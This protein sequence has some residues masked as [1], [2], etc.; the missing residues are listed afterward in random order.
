MPPGH[1]SMP[2]MRPQPGMP[3]GGKPVEKPKAHGDEH[4]KGEHKPD[5]C[6]GH[7]PMDPPGR[8]NFGHGLL[9][10]DNAKAPPPPEDPHASSWAPSLWRYENKADPCDP[11]NEPPPFLA[12]LLNFGVLVFL[13][14]RFGRK[15]IAAALVKRKQTIMHDIDV[16]KKLK[17]DAKDRLKVYKQKFATIEETLA[18]LT[19]EHVAQAEVE[20]KRILA[21]AEERRLRMRRDAEFR[22]EQELKAA[23]V[24]LL[25]EAVV[26]AVVAAE[27]LLKRRVAAADFERVNDDY[28]AS[29]AK[30][31]APGDVQKT[32]PGGAA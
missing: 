19:A 22:I 25:N 26:G 7:G 14:V 11:R 2:G 5:H 20:K 23:R 4:G 12:N 13:V 1:P 28:L 24:E 15:P 17:R 16:A 30:A 27:E 18:E 8:F 29:V 10:V 21:D 9:G 31:M 6:P 3:R 32:Q